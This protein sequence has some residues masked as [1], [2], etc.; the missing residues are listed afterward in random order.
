[1]GLISGFR[2]KLAA[3]LRNLNSSS[4]DDNVSVLSTLLQDAVKKHSTNHSRKRKLNSKFPRNL[5]FDSDCKVQKRLVNRLGKSLKANPNDCEMRASFLS[6]K[7]KY[8]AMIKCKKRQAASVLHSKLESFRTNNPRYFWQWIRNVSGQSSSESIPVSLEKMKEHFEQ[9]NSAQVPGNIQR[10]PEQNGHRHHPLTDS[11]ISMEEVESGVKQLKLHKAPGW[12]GLVPAIFKLFDSN[13]TALLKDIFNRVLTTGVYPLAWSIGIIKPIFKNGDENEPGNYRGITLLNVMGKIFTT[14]IRDRLM[15]WAEE[16]NC[17]SDVQFGFRQG[18]RTCDPIFII[19]SAIQYYKKKSI[20]IYA[21]FVDFQKAFDSVNHAHLWTKL[22]S[23]GVS[24]TMITLLQNM[25]AKAVS[26]VQVNEEVSSQFPCLNGVRQGC[27]LSPLLF[28]LF[29]SD[30]EQSL[31]EENGGIQLIRSRLHL[32]LFADDLVLLSESPEGLQRSL[33]GLAEFCNTWNLKVNLKKTKIVCFTRRRNLGSRCFMLNG[34]T[35]SMATEYKYLGLLLP[36]NGSLKQAIDTLAAQA[37]KATF[38][39]M[40]TA[41]HLQ[42]PKPSTL[43]HLFDALVRPITEYG[44]EAWSCYR[45]E[46]MELTHRRFCKFVLG[47]PTSACNAAVYGDLG[48]YPLEIRRK[49]ATIKYWL[50]IATHWDVSPLLHE[51]FQLNILGQPSKWAQYVKKTVDE[52]GFSGVWINPLSMPQDAFLSNLE[53]RLLDQYQ[54]QWQSELSHSLKL[55]TYRTFKS[56]IEREPYLNLPRH[57]RVQLSRLRSS[58]HSLRVETGRYTLPPTPL[59]ER[60]CPSCN[61]IEDEQHFLIDCS[62]YNGN[63]RR[64]MMDI[65]TALNRSFP[66]YSS[67]EKFIFILSTKNTQL[68]W[69]LGQ[70]VYTNFMKRLHNHQ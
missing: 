20:P 61:V 32:L 22:A 25:Y 38:S 23:L 15:D 16:S 13:L 6:E 39:L 4:V 2:A 62:I 31:G 33:N 26:V 34:V 44:C 29:I 1:M 43:L 40:K 57:L 19:N 47:L 17:L 11:P 53:Q 7:S 36:S 66:H 28:S 46:V 58:A 5:W 69:N 10:I 52:A 12:D 48:R 42:H 30:L 24:S 45:S 49:M 56:K 65:C 54:Q 8:R 68:L 51:A 55:R 50:R 27:T 63:E 37:N 9:L 41:M 3:L 59:E 35:I 14:I 67:K 64:S 18:R 70:F 60:L 21:C